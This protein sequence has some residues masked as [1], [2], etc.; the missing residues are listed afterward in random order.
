MKDVLKAILTIW[1][2]L[3][4]VAFIFLTMVSAGVFIG[5]IGG[6]D[7]AWWVGLGCTVLYWKASSIYRG[8]FLARVED[9]KNK[10][11]LSHWDDD[12]ET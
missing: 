2:L 3:L 6:G 10:A 11:D 8:K 1:Y 12:D 5:L 4:G 9:T 7:N